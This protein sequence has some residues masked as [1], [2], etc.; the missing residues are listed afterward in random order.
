MSFAAQT[1]PAA[2][3]LGFFCCIPQRLLF[4][5]DLLFPRRTKHRVLHLQNKIL[6]FYNA[7][8]LLWLGGEM[9]GILIGADPGAA[10]Q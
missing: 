2:K 10:R 7:W 4:V 3:V 1:V 6:L 8:L 5:K 9:L